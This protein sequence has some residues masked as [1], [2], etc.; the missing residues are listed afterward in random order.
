MIL[1]QFEN[2]NFN[3]FCDLKVFFIDDDDYNKLIII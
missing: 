3:S 2:D 1:N